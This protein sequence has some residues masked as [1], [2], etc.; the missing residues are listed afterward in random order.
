MLVSK[1]FRNGSSCG[2]RW[3]GGVFRSIWC[4]EF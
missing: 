4:K 3:I 2:E 1:K